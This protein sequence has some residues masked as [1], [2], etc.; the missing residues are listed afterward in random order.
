MTTTQPNIVEPTA[1]LAVRKKIVDALCISGAVGVLG[2]IMIVTVQF[3]TYLEVSVL[4]A[5]IV[6]LFSICLTL[7][8]L[9]G[10]S[11]LERWDKLHPSVVAWRDHKLFEKE[12]PPSREVRD[13]ILKKLRRV[14]I[15]Y[16]I[17]AGLAIT[18]TLVFI[19]L[20]LLYPQTDDTTLYWPAA[21]GVGT[22]PFIVLTI[23]YPIKHFQIP[24]YEW[25]RLADREDA[26]LAEIA[27]K[28]ITR[29]EV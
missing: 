7:P 21:T 18:S 29:N 28:Q 27:I 10:M 20:G 25:N 9:F 11:Y 24:F 16:Y 1:L 12:P 17:S 22:L 19:V 15:A 4:N 23:Y 13:R 3:L 26:E 2:L 5:H 14:E 8:F 6:I